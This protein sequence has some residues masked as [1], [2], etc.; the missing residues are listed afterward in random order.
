M[1]TSRNFS[2]ALIAVRSGTNMSFLNSACVV[3][4]VSLPWQTSMSSAL[5]CAACTCA[6]ATSIAD[7]LGRVGHSPRIASRYGA[8]TCSCPAAVCVQGACTLYVA[9]VCRRPSQLGDLSTLTSE[10]FSSNLDSNGPGSR[11]GPIEARWGWC[12]IHTVKHV[13]THAHRQPAQS[14]QGQHHVAIAMPSHPFALLV[15]VQQVHGH[16]P[17]LCARILAGPLRPIRKADEHRQQSTAWADS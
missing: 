13:E 12:V 2:N 17:H 3:A 9:M 4:T 16:V 14:R 7:L 8:K 10:E 6:D 5:A 11:C 1:L 15:G